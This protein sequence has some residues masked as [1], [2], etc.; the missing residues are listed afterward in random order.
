MDFV[1]LGQARLRGFPLI[2]ECF[3]E[4]R[5]YPVFLDGEMFLLLSQVVQVVQETL[6]LIFVLLG[7]MPCMV[8]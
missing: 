2:S 8:S 3:L 7:L 4:T 6:Y 1:A 5:E